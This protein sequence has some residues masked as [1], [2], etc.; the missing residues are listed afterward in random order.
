MKKIAFIAKK[1]FYHILRDSRSLMIVLA[2]PIMMTFLYGY[3]INLDM[4]NITLAVRDYDNSAQSR[5]LVNTFLESAYF[6]PTKVEM[7]G[8]DPE[9]I[10]RSDHAQAVLII[11]PDFSKKLAQGINTEV[12]MMID[13]S[14]NNVAAAV[15]N[16]SSAVIVR[17]N[18]DR[19]PAGVT[20]PKIDLSVQTLYNPDLQSATFFVPGLVAI[21]LIM[22]SAL[23]T[24]VTIAREKETG[25]LEQLLTAPVTPFQILSGKILPYV[26]VALLDG[27]LVLT[28]AKVIFGVPIAGSHLLLLSLGLLYIVTALSL[29]IMIS[30][31]VS[32]QQVAMMMAVMMTVLPSIMLSGF[33]FSIKNFPLPLQFISYIVPARYFVAIIR[34]ILLKGAGLADL[35]QYGLGLLTIT[36]VLATISIRRFKVRIA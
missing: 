36:V 13:G 14:D 21:I 8:D 17:Y 27:M 15:Q 19:I 1:E 31:F 24:S 33:I 6:S 3:A 11:S 10:L 35:A 18:L 2:M 26:F 25:T 32:T 20:I 12:G 7:N 9:T 34:G 4:N 30:T 22:V 5:K 16:Y 23:L 28:F 29:G